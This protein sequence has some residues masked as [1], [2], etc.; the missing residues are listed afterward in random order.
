[1]T[2][3]GVLNEQ[4]RS[5]LIMAKDFHAPDNIMDLLIRRLRELHASVADNQWAQYQ[6]RNKNP[7]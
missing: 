2:L 6:Q 7:S 1:M 3:R 4:S 5:L